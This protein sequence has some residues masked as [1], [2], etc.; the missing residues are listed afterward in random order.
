MKEAKKLLRLGKQDYYETHLAIIN[1]ILPTKLTPK[2]IEVLAAFMSLEGDIA[3]YRFGPSA[4]KIVMK[5]VNLSPAGLSNYIS[6]LIEKKFLVRKGDL[7]EIYPLL[8]PDEQEQ[9]YI[10]KL[11]KTEENVSNNTGTSGQIQQTGKG[12]SGDAEES[13]INKETTPA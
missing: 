12:R 8:I 9:V 1:C 6:Q 7:I 13:I 10:F 2:E 3:Q 4:K 5:L 11:I